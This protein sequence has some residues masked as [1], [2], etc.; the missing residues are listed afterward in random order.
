MEVPVNEEPKYMPWLIH[1]PLLSMA[2]FPE[3]GYGLVI[4]AWHR[5]YFLSY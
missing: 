2:H 4:N 1:S 3:A 5:L